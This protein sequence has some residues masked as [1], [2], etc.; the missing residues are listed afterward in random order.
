MEWPANSTGPFTRQRLQRGSETLPRRLLRLS[1]VQ[2]CVR[3]P[4]A[5]HGRAYAGDLDF[6]L[7]NVAS[8]INSLYYAV[9]MAVWLVGIVNP[10][11]LEAHSSVYSLRIMVAKI[12]AGLMTMDRVGNPDREGPAAVAADVACSRLFRRH[13]G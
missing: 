13:S 8:I 2:T 12:V 11:G 10:F 6:R 9:W 4:C 5:G 7:A 3:P 1:Q